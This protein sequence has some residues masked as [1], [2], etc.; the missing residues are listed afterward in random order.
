MVLFFTIGHI[1]SINS[2]ISNKLDVYESL[3]DLD[4]EK[5]QLYF[6]KDSDSDGFKGI[7][8]NFKI[9][10][11]HKKTF[12]DIKELLKK[13]LIYIYYKITLNCPNK[14]HYN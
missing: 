1:Y 11:K 7:Q 5:P 10:K 12:G 4:P 3:L 13:R 14:K 8:K 6:G 9:Y 2:N